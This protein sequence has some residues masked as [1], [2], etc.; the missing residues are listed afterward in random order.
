MTRPRTYQTEAVVIK[1]TR[2]GEADHILTFYTPDLGKIQGIARGVR[3]PRSK[4]AGH[5][6]LLTHSR[7][8]L[9]RGRNLD[10]VTGAQTTSAFL[11]LRASLW[12]TS[13]GLYLIELVNRFT[14]E[15]VPN[16]ALFDVLVETLHH[17]CQPDADKALTLRHF[18]IHLFGETGYRPQLRECLSCHRALEPGVNSFSAP[19]GG[20]LCPE[21]ATAQ[22]T[23]LPVTLN[24][25]KVLRFLQDND[26]PTADRLKLDQALS[27]ELETITRRYV[28]F[29]LER[30]VRSLAWLDSLR[31]QT[32]QVPPGG[33]ESGQ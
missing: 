31:D 17:L 33:R 13:C 9:A 29:L 24:A 22:E 27:R 11:P 16:P 6:E 4:L 19:A 25:L 3:R 8:S 7:L 32:H 5:L 20:M 2:L 15:Q 23:S 21:C 1:K 18:E 30:D 14:A 10:T 28:R 26:L 12:L